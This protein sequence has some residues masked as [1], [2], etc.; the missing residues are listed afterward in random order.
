[1]QTSYGSKCLLQFSLELPVSSLSPFKLLTFAASVQ[2]WVLSP[3]LRDGAVAPSAFPELMISSSAFRGPHPLEVPRGDL[4]VCLSATEA[5][6]MD[7]QHCLPRSRSG[8]IMD[9]QQ[10]WLTWDSCFWVSPSEE[11]PSSRK[12][13]FSPPYTLRMY[14]I[15]WHAAFLKDRAHSRN[16]TLNF[17]KLLE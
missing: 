7:F 2:S 13:M 4:C 15:V 14:D 6:Y 10:Q 8:E 12:V 3:A 9:Y 1:M 11:G 17:W 5:V 16:K